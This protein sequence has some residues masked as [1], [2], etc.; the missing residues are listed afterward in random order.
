MPKI[1]VQL[2]RSKLSSGDLYF[3]NA[4]VFKACAYAFEDM[5]FP[6]PK[7]KACEIADVLLALAK[8]N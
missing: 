2:Y 5:L 3:E 1:T 6:L 4:N 7:E 8:E